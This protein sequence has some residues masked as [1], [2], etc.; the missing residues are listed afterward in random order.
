MGV[1][2]SV[3]A[4]TFTV[5]S[6][7]DSVDSNP[8][9]GTCATSGGSCTLRAAVQESNALGGADTIEIPSGTYTLTRSGRNESAASTGDLDITQNLTITGTGSALTIID[10]DDI[11]RAFDLIGSITVSIT[12][13]W[14]RDGDPQESGGGIRCQSGSSLTLTDVTSA[15]ARR[16]SRTRTG[17]A[18]RSNPAAALSR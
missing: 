16:R 18:A 5:N 12:G 6:T 4:A 11:D 3:R 9:N 10:A 2:L 7:S 17:T 15:A 1:P 8:G 13:V 14:I